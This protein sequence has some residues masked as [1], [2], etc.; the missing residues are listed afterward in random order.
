MVKLVDCWFFLRFSKAIRI[1]P[2][3][4]AKQSANFCDTLPW[5]VCVYSLVHVCA[6]CYIGMCWNAA[7]LF[8]S[9]LCCFA[10]LRHKPVT[11]SVYAHNIIAFVLVCMCVHT[12]RKNTSMADRCAQSTS[13]LRIYEQANTNRETK[14]RRE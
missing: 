3:N 13:H 9:L 14:K 10:L 6:R 7:V 1:S 5:C 12:R 11:I 8:L 2:Y 4:I